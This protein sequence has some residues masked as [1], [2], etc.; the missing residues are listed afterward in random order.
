MSENGL[1]K[2]HC[3][4]K[5]NNHFSPQIIEHK[6][7]TIAYDIGNPDPGLGQTKICGWV[8]PVNGVMI[9]DCGFLT[10]FQ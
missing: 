5:R 4:N 9:S 6:K 2:F 3:I 1:H 8:K 10:H 7:K